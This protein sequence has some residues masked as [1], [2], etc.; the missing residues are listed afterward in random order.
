L[1]PKLSSANNIDKMNSDGH[2]RR[3]PFE[4]NSFSISSTATSGARSNNEEYLSGTSSTA[5]LVTIFFTNQ[6][7]LRVGYIF[8]G[9]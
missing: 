7:L 6:L 4:L 9:V 5:K 3:F 8:K 1:L 2:F